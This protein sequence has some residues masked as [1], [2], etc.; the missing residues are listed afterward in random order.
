VY[1][2]S[3]KRIALKQGTGLRAESQELRAKSKKGCRVLGVGGYALCA[4]R[5]A[6]RVEG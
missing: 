5:L 1:A 3:A 4:M 2:Q 6:L